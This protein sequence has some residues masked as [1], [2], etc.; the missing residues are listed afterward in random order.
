MFALP[1][2]SIL[3]TIAILF[4]DSFLLNFA[5]AQFT[6]SDLVITISSNGD[7]KIAEQINPMTSISRVN[8]HLIGEKVE[9]ILAVDENGVVLSTNRNNNVLSIDTLGAS[10]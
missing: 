8:V 10:V 2:L 1:V 7:A 9:N 5:Y 4:S 3:L 6:E